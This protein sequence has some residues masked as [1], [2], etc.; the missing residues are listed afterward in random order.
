MLPRMLRSRPA[1]IAILTASLT[2]LGAGAAEAD[3]LV[4]VKGG[5]IWISH[6]DGTEQRQVTGAANNWS[7]PTEDD[8][9]VI[10]AA[11]G[12][13]GVG[14]GVEDT[15]GS[16]IYRLNQQGTSLSEPQETPGSLSTVACPSYAPVSLRVAPDGKH[17]AYHSFVCDQFMVE[18]GTVGGAAFSAGDRMDEFV[19]PY[20]VSNSEY[21]ISRGGVPLFGGCDPGNAEYGCEWWAREVGQQADYGYPWAADPGSSATGFDGLAVSRDGTRFASIEEDAADWTGGAHNVELRIAS[22]SGTPNESNETVPAPTFKCQLSLPADPESTLWF[23]NAGPTFSPDG[24]RLAFAEPDGIHIA[25]VSNLSNCASV[26]APLVIPGAT[27]PFWSAAEEAA[28]AGFPQT[29]GRPG[30][31]QVPQDHTPPSLGALKIKPRRFSHKATVSYTVSEPAHVTFEAQRLVA[32]RLKTHRRTR[33]AGRLSATAAA[34]TN[35]LPLTNRIG[36]RKLAPGRYRLLATPTDAAGNR[37][38]TKSASF[39]IKHS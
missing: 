26:T 30:E 33:P 32:S 37:G 14:A 27:Q 19:F 23:D 1:C 31:P 20:W 5:E 22:A 35:T 25:D 13:G 21:V 17:F 18:L 15:P 34:G 12:Q 36:S 24:T 29:G 39:A 38:A 6:G 11:G 7:W 4:F 9:G 16:E 10:L 28:D 3:S 2:V 8:A